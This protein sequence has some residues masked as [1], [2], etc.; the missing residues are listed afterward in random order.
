[1]SQT[2]SSDDE[3]DFKTVNRNNYQRIQDKVEKV[4]QKRALNR[5]ACVPILRTASV[6]NRKKQSVKFQSLL[7]KSA[8]IVPFEI[9]L[10]LLAD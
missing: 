3:T 9:K 10:I 4:R 7:I 5:V 8:V 2:H 1:M 6:N